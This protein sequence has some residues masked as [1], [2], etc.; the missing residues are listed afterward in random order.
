MTSPAADLTP[1]WLKDFERLLPIR[2]QFIVSGNIRD[3][4]LTPSA[5]GAPLL[6]P[7]LRGLWDALKRQGYRY[8]LIYD[9]ADGVRIYPNEPRGGTG[10][11]AA[12]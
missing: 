11:Q 3:S 12:W 8:L 2:S 1:R 10:D 7:L 9:P 6:V 5:A 4:L